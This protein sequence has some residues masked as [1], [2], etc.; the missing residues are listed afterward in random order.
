MATQFVNVTARL[1]EATLF[2]QGLDVNQKTIRR[3][4]LNAVGSG[5]KK[6]V[7][8]YYNLYLHKQSGALYKSIIK[9]FTRSKKAITISAKARGEDRGLAGNYVFYGYA[10]AKGSTIKAKKHKYL[11]FKVG[12]KWAK[13]TEVKLPNKDFIVS[14]VNYYLDSTQADWDINRQLEKEIAKIEKKAQQKASKT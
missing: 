10:L 9:K 8:K 3:R 2:L 4:V 11:T 12:D 7:K 6:Q 14:P 13:K 5:A 1:D